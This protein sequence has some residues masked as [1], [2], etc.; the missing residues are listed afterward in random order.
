MI[1]NK[2]LLT[3]FLVPAH[4]RA[5]STAS[6]SIRDRFESAYVTRTA[7]LSKVQKKQ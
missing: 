2:T 1:A 7:S 4:A 3:K 5:M 6:A